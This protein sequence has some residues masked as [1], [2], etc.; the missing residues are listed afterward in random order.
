MSKHEFQRNFAVIIGINDYSNGVPPLETAVPDAR[1]L[2]RILEDYKYTVRRLLNQDASLEGLNQLLAAFHAQKLPLAQ[3]V[4]LNENDRIVFYFAGH[5]L[6][7]DALENE[8]GPAGYLVPADAES[9]HISTYLQMQKLHNALLA[10]PCRHLLVILDCCFAGA[11]RWSSHRNA[12]R[13][14][15]VYQERYDRFIRD[16]AWQV[17]ASA[18]HDQKALD[19]V[20]SRGTVEHHS[21][22]AATLFQALRGDADFSLPVQDGRATGDGVITATELYFYLREKLETTTE[23]LHSRQTPG[24]YHLAKHDKGEYIFLVPGHKLNL[25]SAPKLDP[26]NN[27]YRGLE[28][29]DEAHSDLFFGRKQLTKELSFVVC[30]RQLTVVLGASGT[31]KSSLVKAGLLP[32]LRKSTTHQWHILNP[33]RP[34]AFPITALFQ[35]QKQL[36]TEKEKKLSLLDA[37]TAWCNANPQKK[38]LLAIDQFEELVT[39]CQNDKARSQFLQ[40]LEQALTQPQFHIVITL[41][42][43]FEPQFLTSAFPGRW[44]NA[45]FMIPPMTQNELRETIEKP[46]AEQVLYFEPPQLVEQLIN[47]VVQMPGALP[48]L[49]FTLSELYLKYLNR[50]GDNRALTEEDYNE[51]GGVAGSLTRRATQ[52]YENLIQMDSM[53]DYTIRKVMLRMVTVDGGAMARRRVPLGELEYPNAEDNER[54]KK[55]IQRFTDVR[56][57]V[58]GKEPNGDAYVEPAHDALVL[59]WNLLQKWKDD[60]RQNE[61]L[62]LR[63]RLTLAANDWDDRDRKSDYL[64]SRDPRIAVLEKVLEYPPQ[65]NWLNQLETEYVKSSIQKRQDE[66]EEAKERLRISQEQQQ[67]SQARLLATQA[68]LIQRE[69][70]SLL[71]LSTL[72]A[73]ESMKRFNKL[74]MRY[75]LADQ[76]LRQGLVLLPRSIARISKQ[77]KQN[78]NCSNSL[79]FCSD[80]KYMAIANDAIRILEVKSGREVASI[81]YEKDLTVATLSPDGKY[82]ATCC[83]DGVV[84][85]WKLKNQQLIAQIVRAETVQNIIFSPKSQYIVI[86][87]GGFRGVWQLTDS[88]E[89]IPVGLPLLKL[90]DFCSG[91]DPISFSP[92]GNYLAEFVEDSPGSGEGRRQVWQLSRRRRIINETVNLS[93]PTSSE[94]NMAV[95][96]NID[97]MTFSL[98]SKFFAAT[99]TLTTIKVWK[100][101]S[102]REVMTVEH[103]AWINTI[104]MNFNGQYVAAGDRKGE[105]VVWEV[106][107]GYQVT[108]IKD[109]P[110]TWLGRVVFSPDGNYL[111]TVGK[112]FNKIARVYHIFR[113]HEVTRLLHE[114][115]V[116]NIAFSRDGKYIATQEDSNP[117]KGHTDTINLWQIVD[118]FDGKTAIELDMENFVNS[119]TISSRGKYLGMTCSQAHGLQVYDMNPY[120]EVRFINHEGA[121]YAVFSTD[122]ELVATVGEDRT[123]RLWELASGQEL[124]AMEHNAQVIAIAFSQDTKLLTTLVHLTTLYKDNLEVLVCDV[125]IWDITNYK[126][127]NRLETK[128]IVSISPDGQY[129][130][131]LPKNSNFQEKT[132]SIIKVLGGEEVTRI[133]LENEELSEFTLSTDGK[134]LA[135]FGGFYGSDTSVDSDGFI[136]VWDL[137]GEEV[138]PILKL[139]RSVTK[140]VFSPGSRFLA[141][142]VGGDTVRIWDLIS[143]QEVS[144]IEVYGGINHIIFSWDSEHFVTVNCLN[145]VQIWNLQ[146]EV[147]IEEVCSRLTCNLTLEEWDLYLGNEPYQKI[148]PNLP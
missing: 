36:S 85:I 26:K 43:D 119:I 108:H 121:H 124:L 13:L 19:F 21:P 139:G 31:G 74:E 83:Q 68:Q 37:V 16:R 113:G 49:S 145:K 11:F 97:D 18:A 127:V 118:D 67:I 28:S 52:E 110:T 39:M 65:K 76:T 73:V 59:G 35:V 102:G 77:S 111:A 17:I 56:L 55:I 12:M 104:G 120:Q 62:V 128:K 38:L 125:I 96:E 122:E 134:Y 109:N 126:Q 133:K 34:S 81:E 64:W 103:N 82:A 140:V 71:H 137:S 58:S 87:S 25:P 6:A 66:L 60:K 9:G 32:R 23:K 99:V 141:A 135:G 116:V 130:V 105:A 101:P 45:R 7:L 72:L 129:L 107:R 53:Y 142:A 4:D 50:K 3:E 42:L 78:Y 30:D 20:T 2:A 136:Q 57:I 40:E 80:G 117:E 24:L 79:A 86:V 51:L 123:V 90:P 84:K 138:L 61:S 146:P 147:L 41:R 46:A 114:N 132:L 92:D 8:E 69:D 144:R 95:R 91:Q 115:Y 14:P 29:F 22:F 48:L 98:D 10:L 70:I 112:G 27:P 5:G 94:L 44:M 143:K 63:Q 54:V 33:I 93:S 131:I 106:P 47:E 100:I 75:L 89:V 1:E 15:V 88:P 148:C